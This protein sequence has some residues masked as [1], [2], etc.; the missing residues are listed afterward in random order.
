MLEISF[1]NF[2][3]KDIGIPG[4]KS[5]PQTAIARYLL[6]ERKM[7]S[8]EYRFKNL[9]PSLS[10]TTIKYFYQGIERTV[11]LKPNVSAAVLPRAK[12]NTNGIQLQ[13]NWL[14]DNYNQLAAGVDFWFRQR[15]FP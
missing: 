14:L 1:Q 7:Y 9:L 4:G 3:G 13:T 2:S 6:A 11:E 5:I 12:H 8:A 10:N 15:E